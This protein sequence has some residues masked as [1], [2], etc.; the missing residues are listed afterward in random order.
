MSEKKLERSVKTNLI[1]SV[2]N[3][4]GFQH[5]LEGTKCFGWP[6]RDI[7]HSCGKAKSSVNPAS[8]FGWWWST[9]TIV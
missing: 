1:L 3:G 6:L 5:G 4:N 7:D 2:D 9:R 8:R